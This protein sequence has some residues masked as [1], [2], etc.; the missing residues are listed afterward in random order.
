MGKQNQVAEF[1]ELLVLIG[2]R[3]LVS[4]QEKVLD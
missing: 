3:I 2:Q 4:Q 1:V